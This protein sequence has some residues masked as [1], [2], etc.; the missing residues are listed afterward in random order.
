MEP[1]VESQNEINNIQGQNNI[2]FC[3]AY[4]KYGFHEDGL[5]S[6]INVIKKLGVE[7]PWQ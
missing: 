3:G 7:L 5:T 6:A 1:V 2:Y 4:Q